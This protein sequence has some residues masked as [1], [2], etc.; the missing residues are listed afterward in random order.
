MAATTSRPPE[1]LSQNKLY[2]CCASGLSLIFIHPGIPGP[3]TAPKE[4]GENFSFC[5]T[6]F[7][8]HKDHKIVNNFIFEQANENIFSQ[9]T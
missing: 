4:E 3:R 8:S 6:I 1:V 5:P 2:Q 9:N 7:G